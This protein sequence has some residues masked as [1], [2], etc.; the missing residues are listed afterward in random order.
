MLLA[1][2]DHGGP[3]NEQGEGTERC[4]VLDAGDA[5]LGTRVTIEGGEA[6]N[7]P[8]QIDIDTFFSIP[9]EAKEHAVLCGGKALL[10]QG[11]PIRTGIISQ[12]EVH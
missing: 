5:P 8:S 7:T 9:L 11:K 1:A 2:G 4:E 3:P 6:E 10:L 12:G